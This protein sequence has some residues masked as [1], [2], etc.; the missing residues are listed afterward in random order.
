MYT[1]ILRIACFVLL[2]AVILPAPAARAIDVDNCLIC[3][4]HRGMSHIDENNMLRILY[5]SEPIY[6]NSPH[7][8]LTCRSCHDDVKDI[9]HKNIQ[10]VDCLRQCH[11]DK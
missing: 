2:L 3:H 5:I 8:M 11:I 1:C 6:Q 4:K 7:G 10:K 9:P